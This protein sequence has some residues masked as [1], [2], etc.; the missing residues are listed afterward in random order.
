MLSGV[1]NKNSINN[2]SILIF[3]GWSI[4]IGPRG[5]FWRNIRSVLV[6]HNGSYSSKL[7]LW[8]AFIGS[9]ELFLIFRIAGI[10]QFCL[11][12]EFMIKKKVGIYWKICWGFLMPGL[13]IIIFVYFIITLKPLKYGI[14]DLEYPAGLTGK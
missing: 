8:Y 6:Y 7:A 9:N 10:D 2:S 3:T 5:S 14:Y 4:C 11:D 1:S 12:L 13:L